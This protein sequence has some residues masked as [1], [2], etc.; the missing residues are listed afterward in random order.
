[1]TVALTAETDIDLANTAREYIEKEK[2]CLEISR[3]NLNNR[4]QILEKLEKTLNDFQ[5]QTLRI[6]FDVITDSPGKIIFYFKHPVLVISLDSPGVSYHTITRQNYGST[7]PDRTILRFIVNK[8]FACEFVEELVFE[9]GKLIVY[10][11]A[12]SY[13]TKISYTKQLQ[14]ELKNGLKKY[15]YRTPT[16]DYQ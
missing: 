9:K 10:M 4:E 8:F 16:F 2:K 6:K 13:S 11:D 1:M 14:R 15:G 3:A 7:E 5:T 12:P